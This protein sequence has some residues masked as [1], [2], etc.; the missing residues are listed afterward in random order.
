LCFGPQLIIAQR[1][2]GALERIDAIH[3]FAVLLE[4]AL[5]ATSKNLGE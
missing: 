3:G 2:K 1:L 5:V 4:K